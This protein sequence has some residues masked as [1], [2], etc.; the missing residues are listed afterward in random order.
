MLGSRL[1]IDPKYYS[2]T[3][4]VRSGRRRSQ[5]HSG[6]FRSPSVDRPQRHHRSR[7]PFAHPLEPLRLPRGPRP[8]N[9]D[10]VTDRRERD[11]LNYK[12]ERAK[13][14]LGDYRVLDEHFDTQLSRTEI[15]L[16][17][18][19]PN[20][21]PLTPESIRML[22][23]LVSSTNAKVAQRRRQ[24]RRLHSR[25]KRFTSNMQKQLADW[26]GAVEDA[27]ARAEGR[28]RQGPAAPAKGAPAPARAAA[29]A[30][31]AAKAP[32]AAPAPAGK[33]PATPGAPAAR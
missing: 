12:F 1:M 16:I 6:R 25:V 31:P 2:D 23:G 22:V 27:K 14:R 28:S 5:S 20:S 29:P 30:A 32:A 4:S 18:D 19:L 26:I 10:D 8:V 24:L 7:S 9:M 3:D 11:R 15:S 33:A 21:L 13:E 17:Q